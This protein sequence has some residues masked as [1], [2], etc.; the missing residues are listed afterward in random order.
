MQ[1]VKGAWGAAPLVL[2]L[3]SGTAILNGEAVE[4]PPR[5]FKLLAKLATHVGEPVESAALVAAA[6]PDAPWTTPQDLYVLVSKL[7]RLIDGSNRFGGN[8]RNRRGFGYVL[9][10]PAQEVV[11]V[12]GAAPTDDVVIDLRDEEPRDHPPDLEELAPTFQSDPLSP[13]LGITEASEPAINRPRRFK[14]RGAAIAALLAALLGLSWVAGYALS[15][16]FASSTDPRVAAQ[17]SPSPRES[18]PRDRVNKAPTQ[19]KKRPKKHGQ[20]HGRHTKRTSPGTSA[21]VLVAQG[22]PTDS[23]DD[24]PPPPSTD[25]ANVS[26]AAG[27]KEPKGPNDPDNDSGDSK[28]RDPAPPPLPPAPTRYLYHLVNEKTGDHFVTTDSNAASEYEARGYEGGAIARI[29]TYQEDNTKAITTNQGTAYVFIASAPKTEPQSQSLPLW[30]STNNAGDFFYTTSE[31][32]AKQG[33]WTGSL[34]GYVRA[35]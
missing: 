19:E 27:S 17:P 16:Q 14:G 18:A 20:P 22:P 15:S 30:Y 35:L 6:W 32:E 10:L 4:L 28:N 3:A 5:E 11:V 29:Y 34:I 12:E 1:K 33:G 2:E 9:D 24:A 13:P 7:R 26:A 21:T 31:S 8:I 23:T 25:P